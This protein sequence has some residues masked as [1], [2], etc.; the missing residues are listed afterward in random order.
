[1][2]DNWTLFAEELGNS[3]YIHKRIARVRAE[4]E[5]AV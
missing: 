2:I 1:M 3:T 4:A 5:E